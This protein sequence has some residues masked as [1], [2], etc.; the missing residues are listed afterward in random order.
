MDSTSSFSN[1]NNNNNNNTV[2]DNYADNDESA[3]L[4]R[5]HGIEDSM[6]SMVRRIDSIPDEE[7]LSHA[8]SSLISVRKLAFSM[9]NSHKGLTL[10]SCSSIRR[11]RNNN[12]MI[13]SNTIRGLDDMGF[14][15]SILDF[16]TS[17]DPLT[18]IQIEGLCVAMSGSDMIGI[19]FTGSGSGLVFVLP[20]IMIGLK[21]ETFAPISRNEG[22]FG[23]ILCP[24]SELAR[25]TFQLVQEL[26]AVLKES[27]QPEIKALL[28]VDGNDLGIAMRG[29]HIIVATPGRL[30]VML[31]EKRFNLDSCRYLA[32]DKADLVLD[33]GFG[34]DIQSILGHFKGPRQTLLF[35]AKMTAEVQ[36]FARTSL[37][38]PVTLNAQLSD[39]T[40]NVNAVTI[41]NV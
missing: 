26:V 39:I 5:R 14:P 36:N 27:G 37:V 31:A 6:R 21:E 19:S 4:R 20:L 2:I 41:D 34:N 35:C 23:V 32:L 1:N 7:H 11:Q 18:Q 38:K 12:M 16:L 10:K 30:S 40:E 15:N 29:L 22:P 3:Q 9:F 17:L 13:C 33:R 24:S 8:K 28:C 25:H